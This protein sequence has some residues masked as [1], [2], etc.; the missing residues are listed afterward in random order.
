M[1]GQGI[2]EVVYSVGV[3]AMVLTGVIVLIV[4]SFTFKNNDFDRKKAVE[5]GTMVLEDTVYKNKNDWVNFWQLNNAVGQTKTGF[6]GFNY[7]L[8][9]ANI[10][11]NA[12]YPNCG[13]GVTDC[14][15]A[16][17]T[18]NWQGKNPQNMIFSRLFTKNGY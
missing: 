7:S 15:E 12:V 13:I 18:V 6:D 5:L 4:M 3:L 8:E 1:K 2:V 11:G 14:A 10:T 16:K 9:F 17:V